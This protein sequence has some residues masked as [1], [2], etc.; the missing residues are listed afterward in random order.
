MPLRLARTNA[1]AHLYMEL[2]PCENCGE[3][4][5]EP[6]DTIILAEGDLA[7]R[8]SGTCPRCGVYREFVFRLPDEVIIPDPEEPVF[9][10]DSPSTLIDAGEWLW[11]ADLI[12]RSTPAEPED[13]M[14]P[15]DRQQIRLELRTAAAAVGEAA[16]FV[17]P[18]ADTVPADAVW[19]P[20][21]RAVY[22]DE[23]GRFR[24]SRLQVVQRT[25]RNIADR[26][27]DAN[28]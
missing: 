3:R 27:Q 5:F 15:A 19:S 26:F 9:G 16:K 17:P 13:G 22:D 28:A 4:E 11:I 25:Y 8:Y 14:T 2:N 1:E 6:T 12:A 23:P 24:L 20:R 10:D 7:S 18:G 21:G